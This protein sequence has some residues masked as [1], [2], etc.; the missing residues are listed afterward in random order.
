MSPIRFGRGQSGRNMHAGKGRY[1]GYN[2]RNRE[3]R[4]A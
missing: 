4:E 3:A 2:V 1:K